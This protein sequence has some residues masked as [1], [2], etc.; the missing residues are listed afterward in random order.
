MQSLMGWSDDHLHIFNVYGQKFSNKQMLREFDRV[1]DE[2]KCEL[3]DYVRNGSFFIYNYDFG[4]DWIFEISV[5][6]KDYEFKGDFH[7]PFAFLAGKRAAPPEDCGG[8]Y[9]YYDLA[10]AINNP[11][12]KNYEHWKEFAGPDWDPDFLFS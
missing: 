4:D 2:S 3:G 7:E 10:E 6:D 9:G 1:H 12:H 11:S 5:L 8:V